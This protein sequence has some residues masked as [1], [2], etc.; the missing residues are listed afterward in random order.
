[1]LFTTIDVMKALHVEKQ[2][3]MLETK[4]KITPKKSKNSFFVQTNTVV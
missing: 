2:N 1:M 3:N 4:A